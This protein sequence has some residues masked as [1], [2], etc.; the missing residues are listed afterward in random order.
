V[1]IQSKAHEALIT[2]AAMA[3]PTCRNPRKRIAKMRRI[4]DGGD[5]DRLDLARVC[6]DE[7]A[8]EDCGPIR[9]A[10]WSKQTKR[11]ARETARRRRVIRARSKT[12]KK[13]AEAKG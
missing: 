13:K 6:L 12:A 8:A 3:D 2:V 4:L 1:S 9:R 7:L 11:L 5:I 10:L